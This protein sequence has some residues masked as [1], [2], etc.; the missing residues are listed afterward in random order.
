MLRWTP[1]VALSACSTVEPGTFVGPVGDTDSWLG[2]VLTEASGRAYLAGGLT[3]R[4]L[5][6]TWFDVAVDGGAA[7][8]EAEQLS[9]E[10]D[11]DPQADTWTGLFTNVDGSA[12]TLVLSRAAGVE[13]V[14]EAESDSTCPV[15]GVVGEGGTRLTGVY[16]RDDGAGGTATYGIVA[17][18][19]ITGDP[20]AANAETDPPTSLSLT[21][22]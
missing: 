21:R 15:G 7:T 14:Y 8:A 5:H 3:S 9:F 2:V 13:G 16:C 6:H 4:D 1:L 17:E 20:I 11:G 22:L 10:L 18:G 19:E 12:E